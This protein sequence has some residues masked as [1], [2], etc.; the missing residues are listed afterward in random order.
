MSSK[1]SASGPAIRGA[2]ASVG[3]RQGHSR[4]RDPPARR[5][6]R[7]RRGR[8]GGDHRV[9]PRGLE[10][11]SR[12]AQAETGPAVQP[13]DRLPL[14]PRLLA[15]RRSTSA[16]AYRRPRSGSPAAGSLRCGA[17]MGPLPTGRRR[18][19]SRRTSSGSVR[20]TG[21]LASVRFGNY[22][23]NPAHRRGPALAALEAFGASFSSS[24]S[25]G[26]GGGRFFRRGRGATRPVGR[27]RSTR[28]RVRRRQDPPR[29]RSVP[30]PSR[31]RRTSPS[32]PS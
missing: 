30:S 1:V 22:E 3:G 15:S 23:P 5:A 13:C 28:R 24:S 14:V 10:S 27:R 2:P 21:S 4:P 29:R 8:R 25:S 19:R 32:P 7:A 16:A 18:P 12:L 9:T 11:S 31:R 26:D 17:L 6:R 20:A